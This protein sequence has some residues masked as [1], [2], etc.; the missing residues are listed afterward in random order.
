MVSPADLPVRVAEQEE[1]ETLLLGELRVPADGIVAD[2]QDRDPSGLELLDV[3]AEP[4]P[5]VRSA[6]GRGPGVEPQ[7][8]TLAPIVRETDG[9][10]VVGGD[11]EVR[12]LLADSQHANLLFI[13]LSLGLMANDDRS[14]VLRR[15]VSLARWRRLILTNTLLVAAAAVVVSLL[16][17]KWYRSDASVYPPEDEGMSMRSLSMILAA[18]TGAGSAGHT[19]TNP[20]L[21]LLATPS[22][23]YAAILKSRSVREEII[24]K[25]DLMTVYKAKTIEDALK[26]LKSRTK[27]RVGTEG[28]VSLMV[29]DKDPVKA[30]AMAGD[31]LGILDART[32]ERRRSSAGA[33]REFLGKRVAECRDSLALAEAALQRIQ[34]ETGIL[35]P[36]DQTRALV[37]G[38]VQIELGRKM[39]EVE[40]GMLRAQVGPDD[41]DRT[42]LEREIGLYRRQLQD[43]DRGAATPGEGSGGTPYQVPLSEIPARTAEYGRALRQM[44]IQE[45]L[46]ELLVEQLE[47]YKIME[48]R[49]TPTIQVLDA[50]EPPQKRWRPIRWLICSIATL[51]AFVFS[52]GLAFVLDDIERMRRIDPERWRTFAAVAAHLHPRRWF[53][54]QSD[55]PAP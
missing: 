51:L 49:D 43:I 19:N 29:I 1:R 27:I 9:R 44:K 15:L 36:D 14:L 23:V 46:Y 28:I 55:L 54:T 37:N 2:P 16:L 38:A 12:R 5:L 33:V 11:G 32:R 45:G 13:L 42:R 50:P 18:A 20:S 25:H 4:A 39:R 24:R 48:K 31:Y 22:D 8:H 26:K 34:E 6:S 41:P 52:S 7:H 10:T 17:P 3:V 47:Q 53:S 21:P 35:A 40:L 30:A